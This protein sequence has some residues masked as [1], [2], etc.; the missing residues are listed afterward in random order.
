MKKRIIISLL[1]INSIA[2]SL[3]YSDLRAPRDFMGV[4]SNT[5][6]VQILKTT[7]E[8]KE[9]KAKIVPKK[10]TKEM[11]VA[12]KVIQK[13]LEKTKDNWQESQKTKE[14]LPAEIIW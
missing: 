13:P 1:L 5:D 3:E 9:Q 10:E 8:Q 6:K 11:E 7:F 12:Q 14:A 2:Y 4:V